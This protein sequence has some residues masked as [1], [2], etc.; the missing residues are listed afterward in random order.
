MAAESRRAPWVPLVATLVAA[1][2]GIA[3]GTWQVGRGQQKR[4]LE[5]RY[6]QLGRDAPIT[7]SAAE[8]SAPDVDLRR[9]HA[10]GTFEP[11]YSVY[12]DNRVMHGVAGYHVIMPMRVSDKR[13]V[14]VNRG[15]VAGLPDRSR[16]PEVRTP[17]GAV[18]VSGIAT[19][20]AKRPFELSS[21]VMEGRVW[22]NL[23]V[24]R[25]R[26]AYG[27][28]IQ[29]FVI[30]QDSALDDGL[31]REWE[32]LDFGIERHYAYAAQWFLLSATALIFYGVA[33]VKR[34]RNNGKEKQD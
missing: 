24:E 27:L 19:V 29:P 9:V 20:P 32:P 10:H 7:V 16:L 2:V 6:E 17:S 30:R 25:Y 12:V 26:K 31:T 15:W 28:P 18:E 5:A 34:R 14:L 11:G 3:L 4:D 21:E 13:Y 8:L 33:Y 1:A 22:Q 23:T